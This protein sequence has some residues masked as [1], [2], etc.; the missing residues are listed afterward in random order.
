MQSLRSISRFDAGRRRCHNGREVNRALAKRYFADASLLFVT[1]IWGTTFVLVQDAIRVIPVF[2]FLSLRFL[3]GGVLLMIP[4]LTVSRWRRELASPAVWMHGSLLGFWLGAGYALQTFGLLYTTAAQSGFITGLCVV[5]VPL[6]AWVILRQRTPYAAWI[7]VLIATGGLYLL[8]HT[9]SGSIN[10]GDTLTLACAIAFA[11]QIVYVGKYA[12]V[13]HPLPLAAVQ[14]VVVGLLS[15]VASVVTGIRPLRY[16]PELT[17][18]TVLWSLVIC[19]VLATVLA[20][21]AQTSFQK[22][23]TPTR[24]ALIFA[25]EPVF[26]AIATYLWTPERLS[27]IAWAG[28]GLILLGML[29]AEFGERYFRSADSGPGTV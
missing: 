7:G 3:V 16:G 15:L 11:I 23:T 6:F 29:F 27:A 24:T 25:T 17:S 28:C 19:T 14:I 18:P 13:H 21:F 9:R 2:L 5:L 20:Y 12:P 26:A 22:F 1:L 4:T 10:V 8:A